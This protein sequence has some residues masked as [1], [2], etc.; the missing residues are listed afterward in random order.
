MRMNNNHLI[1]YYYCG[2]F[3]SCSSIILSGKTRSIGR[4]TQTSFNFVCKIVSWR[5]I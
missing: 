4:S 3:E 5:V 1:S 2:S